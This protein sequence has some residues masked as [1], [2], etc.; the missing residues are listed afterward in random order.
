MKKYGKAGLLIVTLV[1]PALIFTFLRFFA[2]NHYNVPFYHPVTDTQ[3]LIRG[4]NGDTLFYTVSGEKLALNG[5]LTVVS[6]LSEQCDDSCRVMRDNLNRIYALQEG[7]KGL[8][9][10]SLHER[11]VSDSSVAKAGWRNIQLSSHDRDSILKWNEFVDTKK[12]GAPENRWMLIDRDGHIR[13][14]YNGADSEETDRLMA[15]I[16]ILSIDDQGFEK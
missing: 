14:Y 5:N 16:K 12:I 15:E 11:T 6:Y 13:G 2:T 3:G 9:L 7:V 8:E 4:N 1:I 10:L